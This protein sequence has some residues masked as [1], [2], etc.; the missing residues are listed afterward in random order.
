MSYLLDAD[1]AISA[2]AGRARAVSLIEQLA[3]EGISIS[4]VTVGE[5]YEGAFGFPGVE[6]HLARFREFLG[7][8]RILNLNDDIMMRFAE[9]RSLLRRRGD[10]IADFDL[11]LASTALH[12]DLVVLSSN[13]KHLQRVPNLKLYR[14]E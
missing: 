9:I 14:P 3:S 2:L 13:Y 7:A 4:L 11:L 5:I 8:F 12:Y 6:A 10:L 1:W